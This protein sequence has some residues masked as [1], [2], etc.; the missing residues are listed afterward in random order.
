MSSIRD[1]EFEFM[2]CAGLPAEKWKVQA[3][4]KSDWENL[5]S[6]AQLVSTISVKTA[7]LISTID[8]YQNQIEPHEN[9][10]PDLNGTGHYGSHRAWF[11]MFFRAKFPNGLVVRL[12]GLYS[13]DVRKNFV[14][15]LLHEKHDQY[16]N[17]NGQS[18]FQYFDVTQTGPL[19]VESLMLNISTLNVATEPVLASDIADIFGVELKSETNPV[20]YSMKSIHAE[21]FGGQNGYLRSSKDVLEGIRSLLP[22]KP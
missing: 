18:R 12:P 16:S 17:I 21:K 4:P 11:E 9:T 1:G 13:S 19:I 14:H 2:V 22:F 15:D 6:L 10:F 20:N 8:V 7:V 5:N 3:D